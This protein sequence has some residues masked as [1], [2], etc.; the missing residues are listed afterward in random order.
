MGQQQ[1]PNTFWSIRLVVNSIGRMV[2]VASVVEVVAIVVVEV[3]VVGV[4][5]AEVLMV[6]GAMVVGEG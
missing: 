1:V 3:I 4:G 6:V 5:V 2:V